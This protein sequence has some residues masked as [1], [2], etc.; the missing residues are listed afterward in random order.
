MPGTIDDFI[1]HFDR[2]GAFD[3]DEVEQYHERFVSREDEDRDFDYE[4]YHQ[5]VTVYLGQLP[6]DEFEQEARFAVSQAT[7]EQ[8][9]ELLRV[10]LGVLLETADGRADIDDLGLGSIDPRRMSEHDVAR[11]MNY[12]RHKRPEL[13]INIVERV[14]EKPRFLKELVD[15]VV[16]GALAITAKRLSAQRRNAEDRPQRHKA[17]DRRAPPQRK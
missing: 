10:L 4:T 1:D 3:D 16:V 12:A 14:E 6:D 13:L 2:G 11:L 15:P 7:P 9:Q 5:S 8:R 17:E